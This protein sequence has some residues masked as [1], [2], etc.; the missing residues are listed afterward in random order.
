VAAAIV[1]AV[2]AYLAAGLVPA[3]VFVLWG[4]DRIDP[5]AH[6]AYAFRPL[7]LPGL[8]LLWPAVLLRWLVLERRRS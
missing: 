5:S 2:M 3:L 6:G 1:H 8:V 7:L 4:I